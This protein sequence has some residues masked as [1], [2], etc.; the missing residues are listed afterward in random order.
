M[1]SGVTKPIVLV[2]MMGTGKS[3]I[4]RKLA[5]KLNLQFYDSDKIIEERQGLSV[6]DI[7]DYRGAEFFKNLEIE[8]ISEVLKYGVVVLST[9][10][11]SFLIPEVRE[12][13]KNNAISIWL[14]TTPEVIHE[15]VSRR[16]T[17][18][19]IDGNNRVEHIE[20]MI[21]QRNNFYAESDIR[22]ETGNMEAHFVVD[23][24][25]TR[26]KKQFGE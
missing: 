22:V 4:G 20:Q 21:D 15:R 5:N 3:T 8:V 12:V 23:S 6:R 7:H 2:G 18:P 13:V 11:E 16:N 17:R 10:G 1:K 24:I 26:L 14:D 25:L 19:L 9:G